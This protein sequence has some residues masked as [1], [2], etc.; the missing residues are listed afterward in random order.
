VI[1][2]GQPVRFDDRRND[3]WFDIIAQPIFGEDGAVER[4]ALFAHDVTERRDIEERLAHAQK[5]EAV[6]ELTGGVAHEFN[7]LLMVLRDNLDLLEGGLALGETMTPVMARCLR[8]SS[9][10]PISPASS[11]PS[12][13]SIR[14]APSSAT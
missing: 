6:G 12:P 7:N 9:A 1:D 11:Y 2:H 5:L 13:A 14:C 10:A 4:V 3:R 8:G